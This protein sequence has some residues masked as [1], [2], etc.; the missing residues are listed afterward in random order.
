M[1]A[2]IG[3]TFATWAIGVRQ[4]GLRWQ[5]LGWPSLSRGIRGSGVGLGLGIA[6][7]GLAVVAAY[8]LSETSGW[9]LHSYDQR[10]MWVLIPAALTEEIMFRGVPLVLMSAVVG[11]LRAVLTI[12][13]LFALAHVPQYLTDTAA[14]SLGDIMLGMIGIGTFCSSV[15]WRA[16]AFSLREDSGLRSAY[17]SG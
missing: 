1:S 11:R 7:I 9:R 5:E 10:P 8:L 4:L 16:C 17:I 3:F 2:L 13:G 6:T 14:L 15:F 12:A